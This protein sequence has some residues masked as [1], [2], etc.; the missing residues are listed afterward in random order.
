MKY[1]KI[2]LNFKRCQDNRFYRT[3]LVKE[4]L[5]LFNL[6]CAIV[7]AFGGSFEHHFLFRTDSVNYCPKVYINSLNGTT[8]VLMD[9]Y[10]VS[11]L[12][13]KFTFLY[14]MNSQW[15]F[16]GIVLEEEIDCDY[17]K[18]VIL[19]DGKGQGIWEDR[20]NTLYAYFEGKLD[21][22]SLEEDEENKYFKPW[23]KRVTKFGDFDTAFNL[24]DEKELF[25]ASYKCDVEMYKEQIDKIFGIN[26]Y[27]YA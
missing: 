24:D 17:N 5:N 7:T 3:L 25:F 20:I 23:N 12:S 9:K 1:K 21:P 16:E 27:S 2:R 8:N 6:G 14:D 4:D 11:N 19:L 22:N 15:C 26:R 13:N 18:E 10:M